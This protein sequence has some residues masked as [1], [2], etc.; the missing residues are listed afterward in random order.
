MSPEATAAN[1]SAASR[2]SAREAASDSPSDDTTTASS[3]PGVR[4]TKLSS[5][6]PTV[7][8]ASLGSTLTAPLL[9]PD[10]SALRP[11]APR[12]CPFGSAREH[13][14][15]LLGRAT[16]RLDR[17]SPRRRGGRRRGS[18]GTRRARPD[19]LRAGDTAGVAGVI[20]SRAGSMRVA[21]PSARS[22]CASASSPAS[23]ALP[24]GSAS[25][26]WP[27]RASSAATRPT[28]AGG[29]RGSTVWPDQPSSSIG[30]SLHTRRASSSNWDAS[31]TTSSDDSRRGSWRF[32]EGSGSAA[33]ASTTISRLG[34][35]IETT[36]P[37][38]SAGDRRTATA[39]FAARRDTT[40]NPSA[41]V[42]E[43]PSGGGLASS[44]LAA[45]SAVASMPTPWSVITTS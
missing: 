32:A 2:S 8:T 4:S 21:G 22:P 23:N 45:P 34:M 43:K 27:G 24:W 39:C 17:R 1:R 33:P 28:T 35:W 31:G 11:P 5:R 38:P 20:G 25:A 18:F 3:T 29:S 19:S 37:P 14:P 9:R 26:R 7:R 44:S 42:S 41:L 13:R 40:V 12:A 30:S 15:H 16:A 10:H 6:N 36:M